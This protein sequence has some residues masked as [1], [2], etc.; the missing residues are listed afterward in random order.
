M[1]QEDR[2]FRRSQVLATHPELEAQVEIADS[3][4]DNPVCDDN[5]CAFHRGSS[6]MVH[7]R[8]LAHYAATNIEGYPG[9]ASHYWSREYTR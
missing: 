7:L 4:S 6:G 9:A 1:V 2:C 8:Q 5:P 3:E